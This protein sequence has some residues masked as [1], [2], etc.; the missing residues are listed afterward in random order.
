MGSKP[1][2]RDFAAVG[3]NVVEQAIGEKLDGSSLDDPNAGKNPATVA[4]GKLGG[5]AK[6]GGAAR[7][8]A[9][10][11][12]KRSAIAKR[13]RRHGGSATNAGS[14]ASIKPGE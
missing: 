13:R 9:L 11:P 6:K 4:L 14:G 1:R 12:R 3:R 2:D 10:S 7:A 5:G 8:A